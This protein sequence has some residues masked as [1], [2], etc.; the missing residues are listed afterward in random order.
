MSIDIFITALFS[1]RS[2]RPENTY[3]RDDKQMYVDRIGYAGNMITD[4]IAEAQA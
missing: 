3:C 4:R 2:G 1:V